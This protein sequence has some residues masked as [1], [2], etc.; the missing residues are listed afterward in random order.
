[1][2]DVAD[3]IAREHL[4]LVRV[5]DDF[6]A[7]AC[8]FHKDGQERRP[9]F[10]I[11]RL[12]GEWGCFACPERGTNLRDLLQGL[13][14]RSRKLD[15]VIEEAVREAKQHR[16][17]EKVRR[18]KKARAEFRGV[19]V[20]PEALLG[21]FDWTPIKLIE[22]NFSEEIL[23]AHD[24]GFDRE[25]ERITF[26]IRDAYGSL[27]G[28][29][30]RTVKPDGYPKYKVYE[31]I[32]EQDGIKSNNELGEWFPDYSAEGIR[33]H[34]WRAHF[35]YSDIYQDKSKQLIIVE[36]YKAA[37]W[38]VQQGWFNTVAL[39]GSRMSSAQERL[40]RRMGTETWIFLDNNE[41]GITGTDALQDRLG[42]A[43]F[44]VYL[45]QYPHEYDE[46]CQPSDLDGD[47]IESILSSAVR[48]RG[49]YRHAGGSQRKLQ[50]RWS[51]SPE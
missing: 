6:I 10:W 2:H 14:I 12:T 5:K 24:I 23:L 27:I 49:R 36:G 26:P 8:P 43:T 40:V 50:K 9:S 30:G 17:I 46:D 3:A 16:N 42:S 7:S 39:M 51:S 22:E 44:P 29:S 48:A 47:E 34:L 37:M 15:G 33:D 4:R 28:I 11:N 13:G 25:R 21:V 45:C 18:K 19:H 38:L 41:A 35:I 32:T 31:G 20:L 1:M